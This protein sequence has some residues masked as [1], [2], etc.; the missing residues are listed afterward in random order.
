MH[1]KVV[2][3]GS[4]LCAIVLGLA[5]LSLPSKLDAPPS[6]PDQTAEHECLVA[7]IYHEARGE[8][9][10]AKRAVVE[11]IANRSFKSGKSVC[12]VVA[13]KRQFSWYARKGVAKMDRALERMLEE[14]FQ[15]P[16][17]LMNEKYMWFYSGKQPVWAKDMKCRMIGRLNFCRK[18]GAGTLNTVKNHQPS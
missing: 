13:A 5:L 12:E 17:V 7:A 10:A 11:V 1:E 15:H 3:Y 9:Q 14:T 8:K 2:R 4:H 18:N 6:M 16:K